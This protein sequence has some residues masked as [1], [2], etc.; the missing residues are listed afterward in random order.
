MKTGKR[1]FLSIALISI[2]LFILSSMASAAVDKVICVPWQ[3]D[4]N[5]QHTIIGAAIGGPVPD[6]ITFEIVNTQCSMPGTWEFFLNGTS[7]GTVAADPTAGCTCD[8]ALQSFT[9]SNAA[10]LASGAWQI[11]A[12]NTLR[13]VLTGST[14]YSWIRAQVV[15]GGSTKTVCMDDYNGG[16]CTELNLCSASYRNGPVDVSKSAGGDLPVAQLKGVIKTTDGSQIWYKWVFGDGNE[17]AIASLSGATKYNVEITHTYTAATG[18]PF[19]AKLQVANND[20]ISNPVEDPYLLKIEDNTLDAQINIAIDNGLWWLYKQGGNHAYFSY[21]HTYDGSPQMTWLQTSHIYTLASPTASAIHAFAINNHKINGDP[22]KDP[23][24]EAVQFGMNYLMKGYNYYTTYP[25]LSAHSIGPID[26]GSGVFDIP[27]GNSNGYGIQVYDWANQRPIYESG[28]IMDAIIASGVLPTD[29]TGRDFAKTDGT[30]VKNWTYGEVLQDMADMYAW[31]QSDDTCSG[32]RCGSWWYGWNSS[33]GDNS[34]SQWAAI[35][36]IPAQQVP[37]NVIVPN[38]VKTYNTNWLAASYLNGTFG[39]NSAGQCN[40]QCLN[41]TPSG[42]VQ[43][44]F[45]G[46]VGYDNPSTPADERDPKWIGAEKYMADNWNTLMNTGSTSWGGNRTYGWYAMAK[47]MRL[48][49]HQPVFQI[50]KTDGTVFDWYYGNVDN[51]GMAQRIVEIQYSDGHWTGSLTNEPL[52][53]AWMIITLRPTLFAAA[54]IACFNAAPN[55]SYP[56]QD[57]A[58]DPSCSGHS[59]TGKSI[60]NLTLFEWDWNNDGTYDESTTTPVTVTHSFSCASLPCTYPVKLKVTDDSTPA[61]TATY[62]LDIKITNPPHPPVAKA[63]GPYMVSM[64]SNDTLKLDGSQ[65][66]DPNEGEHEAGCPT[67][68]DDSIIAWD[69]D[70][71]PPLTGFDDETGE[72]VT[73]NSAAIASYFTAG[74]HDIG[75]RVTDNTAL[76][77]PTSGQTN[78]TH[79]N[80]GKVRVDAGCIC[81]L[82]ARVKS[83]KV[84][85]TWTHTGAASYDIYRST[86]GP[87]TGFVLIADDHV[88]NYATYLD[89][90]VVNGTTYYYRVVS[91]DGCGSNAASATPR[92]R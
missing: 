62:S 21:P 34:A 72:L 2:T 25:A 10:L 64:C 53:T 14:Y 16:S 42:M 63:G 7:L 46:Q 45:A 67:C 23:Y 29:L 15:T 59:E 56:D 27:D 48:A 52:T 49:V 54:P 58:F 32:G 57:I 13:A 65:S 81:N 28:Q 60:A 8:P 41:T 39:Y 85:I 83:G 74:T 6:S 55:P 82:A 1:V 30:I 35:G 75:L 36:M 70:L 80:F 76:A 18:T 61:R 4:I 73:L 17:S 69:W 9:V 89:T 91:S 38:W 79:S 33:S 19:T 50:K 90:T 43:M 40:D 20:A 11:S 5:K 44:A 71:T 26:R 12:D 3:G 22:D 24:V 92:L 47:A 84:Q 86:E 78:L 88:T 51:K 31:G 68:P 66:Y 77:Y 87:N 37:W